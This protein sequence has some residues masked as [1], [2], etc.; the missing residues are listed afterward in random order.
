MSQPPPRPGV[1]DVWIEFLGS[2]PMS[3]APERL[4]EAGWH[5]RDVGISRYGVPLQIDNGRDMRL[6]AHEEALDLAV[7]LWAM[8]WRVAA[9]VALI[10]AW[11]TLP[12]R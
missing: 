4:Y 7:Y 1:G 12:R 11:A 6:D 9:C 8:R 2:M 10:L 3:L 5:R